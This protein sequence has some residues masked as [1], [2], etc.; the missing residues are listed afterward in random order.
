VAT[1]VPLVVEPASGTLAA[2]WETGDV[3]APSH[4][5]APVESLPEKPHEA[6]TLAI[7][8]AGKE[9][10]GGD[11]TERIA[12]DERHGLRPEVAAFPWVAAPA[13]HLPRC[14]SSAMRSVA[15]LAS[16]RLAS[17]PRAPAMQPVW[18]F[19]QAP[20]SR[21]FPEM[22]KLWSKPSMMSRKPQATSYKLE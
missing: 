9:Q 1:S 8:A 10:G 19:G 20:R 5:A 14:V 3:P 12:D 17:A 21:D 11:A 4:V 7:L 6:A 2:T 18:F 22:A 13:G 15:S 16:P